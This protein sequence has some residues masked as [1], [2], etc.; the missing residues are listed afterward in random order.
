[1]GMGVAGGSAERFNDQLARD[2][3]VYQK[4]VTDINLKVE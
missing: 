4:L 2:L 3:A 1:M